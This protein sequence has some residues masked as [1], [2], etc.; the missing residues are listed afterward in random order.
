[1]VCILFILV[2]GELERDDK[3]SPRNFQPDSSRKPAISSKAKDSS[4][5]FAILVSGI[6]CG[7]LAGIPL[8]GR[9]HAFHFRA[10]HLNSGTQCAVNPLLNPARELNPPSGNGRGSLPRSRFYCVA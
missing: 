5:L 1:M 10:D 7:A 2:G 8:D 4:Y 9:T 6:A 3:S